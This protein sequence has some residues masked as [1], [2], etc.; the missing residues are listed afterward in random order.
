MSDQAYT[1]RKTP[2]AGVTLYAAKDL[3]AS[4]VVLE[5]LN[6]FVA[7]LDTPML[8]RACSWCFVFLEEAPADEGV[9]LGN[10]SGCKIP[11][12]CGKVGSSS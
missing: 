10:C 6:P 2:G 7:V 3:P 8:T 4:A 1:I 11:R 5:D 12:Y 9:K